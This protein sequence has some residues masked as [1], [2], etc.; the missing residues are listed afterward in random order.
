M[1]TVIVSGMARCGTSLTM[2][3]L[4]ACGLRCAGDPPAF[5]PPESNPLSGSLTAEWIG[6]FDAI[7]VIDP[8]RSVFPKVSALVL[9][10]DRDPGE[11]A[12]SQLKLISAMMPGLPIENGAARR[13]RKSLLADRP[14]A[15]RSFLGM[16]V[17]FLQ[18]EEAIRDPAKFTWRVA[19]FLYPHFR[20]DPARAAACVRSRERGSLCQRGLDMEIMLIEEYHS[21]QEGQP[22]KAPA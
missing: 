10:L 17:Q 16:P 4:H 3:M 22:M 13:M 14:T 21:R 20:I 1:P 19:R 2:Q 9:W 18:F 7:K 15:L 11:Q 6:Q 5:E 8:H 12:K